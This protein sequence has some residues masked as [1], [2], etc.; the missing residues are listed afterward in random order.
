MSTLKR[1]LQSHLN[2][3]LN[4]LTIFVNDSSVGKM[5]A[6]HQVDLSHKIDDVLQLKM[7]LITSNKVV[8]EKEVKYLVKISWFLRYHFIINLFY[9]AAWVATISMME[10]TSKGVAFISLTLLILLALETLYLFKGNHI[11]VVIDSQ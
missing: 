7:G 2:W 5:R 1:S 6:G 3:G 11:R 4:N 8:I 9:I 10:R